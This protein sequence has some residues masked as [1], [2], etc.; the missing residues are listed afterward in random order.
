MAQF[1]IEL[2]EAEAR[3]VDNTDALAKL[4]VERAWPSYEEKVKMAGEENF[5][6][7]E[8]I[9]TINT[10]DNLWKDHLLS[11]DHL[12]GGIG[13][14][15]FGQKDPLQEYKKEGYDLFVNMIYNFKSE[16]VERLFRVVITI[17]EGEEVAPPPPPPAAEPAGVTY[18]RGEVPGPAVA[19]AEPMAEPLAEPEEEKPQPVV[20]SSEKVGRNDPC[21]CGS[22]K[23]YK[24]CCGAA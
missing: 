14:R 19:A 18:G 12:K 15:G 8:R 4:I 11:M 13:L 2:D 1:G 21:T 6:E 16:I 20:R 3:G 24:K 9:I 22:G 5:S 23:K 7:F 17:D 10:L